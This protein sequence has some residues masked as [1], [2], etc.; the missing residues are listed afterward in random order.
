M[1]KMTNSSK[2]TRASPVTMLK[3]LL[4]LAT[5][6][7][8]LIELDFFVRDS[9]SAPLIDPQHTRRKLFLLI[10]FFLAFSHSSFD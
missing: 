2:I 7:I 9:F 3:T 6:I 4:T 10:T 8:Y 1:A 5:Y